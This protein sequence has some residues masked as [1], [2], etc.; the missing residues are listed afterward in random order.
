MDRD[1]CTFVIYMIHTCADRWSSSPATV[2]KM[3]NE[4]GCISNYLVPHYDV[5]HTQSSGYVAEDI[6]EY[7]S[8]RGITV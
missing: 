4:S 3:L 6:E 5:L 7:L 8:K 2:Y 1:S